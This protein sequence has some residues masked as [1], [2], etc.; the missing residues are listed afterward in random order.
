MIKFFTTIIT[1]LFVLPVSSQRIAL[2]NATPDENYQKGITCIAEKQISKGIGLIRLAA[3][4]G[5]LDA[6][7]FLAKA[8]KE[9]KF[10]HVNY[11][12]SYYWFELAA[13]QG[14]KTATKE[15]QRLI[16]EGL[17]TTKNIPLEGQNTIIVQNFYGSKEHGSNVERKTQTKYL[18]DID[19]DIPVTTTCND[20]TFV[21]II[22]NENYQ[23]ESKVE[24]AI[25]DGETFKEY[26]IKTFGIPENH[27]KLRKDAT[28]NNIHST[29]D[30]LRS[31][32]TIEKYKDRAKIIF[33]YAGHGFPD[34]ATGHTFILPSDGKGNMTNTGLCLSKLYLDLSLL[35][36]NN[37]IVFMDACFS[38]AQRGGGMIVSA[39]GVAI[40]AKVENPIGKNMT[41]FSAATGDETAYPYKKENHGLFT[42][43]LLKAIKDTKGKCTL[44]RLF[45]YI[46]YNVTSTALEENGKKQT[47]TILSG[48]STWNNMYIK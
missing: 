23:E 16:N 31:I 40:K 18:S 17:Y 2:S 10:G 41:I 39:R 29:M 6:Q 34:E 12:E 4:K 28:L 9:G 38:G 27:I 5:H 30:W 42:Y 37:I 24:F 43:F 45:D 36:V 14:D 44:G 35:P 48:S 26:C 1:V 47:P 19:K 32:T 15:L 8:A 33:Y 3:G 11:D 13:K 22:A 46:H 7:L 25:N 20:T 21:I